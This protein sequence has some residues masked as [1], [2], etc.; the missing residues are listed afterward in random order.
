MGIE[1]SLSL[2]NS[3]GTRATGV[4]VA[5]NVTVN[6]SGA[7]RTYVVGLRTD[8]LPGSY[9]AGQVGL[10]YVVTVTCYG[11]RVFVSSLFWVGWTMYGPRR[12]FPSKTSGDCLQHAK[13]SV[14]GWNESGTLKRVPSHP[15]L[16]LDGNVGWR[17]V[18]STAVQH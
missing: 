9:G 11:R 15:I 2:P 13:E 18:I 8:T 1:A 6:T 3:R 4:P 17:V 7:R 14:G 10:P 5:E 16:V 12:I